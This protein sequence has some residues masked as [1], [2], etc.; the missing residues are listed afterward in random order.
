MLK[1]K[2]FAT[3]QDGAAILVFRDWESG[4]SKNQNPQLIFTLTPESGEPVLKDWFP[5]E[6]KFGWAKLESFLCAIGVEL[7]GDEFDERILDGLLG[8]EVPAVILNDDRGP[9][10]AYYGEPRAVEES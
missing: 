7:E 6:T 5:Y 4:K 9:K 1:K 2:Q 3:L 8:L 10:V